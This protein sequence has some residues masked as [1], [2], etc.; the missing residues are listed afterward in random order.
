MK[1]PQSRPSWTLKLEQMGGTGNGEEETAPDMEGTTLKACARK[2]LGFPEGPFECPKG[3]LA[4]TRR[5]GENLP[6][7]ER[8]M[9]QRSPNPLCL[10]KFPAPNKG[11]FYDLRRGF[12]KNCQRGRFQPRRAAICG[13]L[14]NPGREGSLLAG[15]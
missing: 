6:P 9:A 4:S 14:S 3:E 12:N 7:S 8:D 1:A 10:V 11:F 13:Q 2:K 15:Q 5:V